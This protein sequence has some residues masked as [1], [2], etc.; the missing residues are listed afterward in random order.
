MARTPDTKLARQEKK[1]KADAAQQDAL[2]REVDE[3]VRQGDMEDFMG[4]W[5]KPLLALIVVGLLGFAG[6]LYWDRQQEQAMESDSEALVLALDALEAGN[7]D[8][9]VERLA[10]IEGDGTAAV[11]AKMLRAGMAS[12]GGNDAEAAKLFGEVADNAAAPEALRDLARIR[13]TA[14]RFD[15]MEPA[16]VIAALQP[17]AVPGEPFFA[18]AGELVAHAYLAQGNR[19]EA[20]ALFAQI[21]RD[22]NTPESARARMV[23]MA[24]LLGVD[25]VDDVQELLDERRIDPPAAP[26]GDAE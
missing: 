16:A 7:N 2:M 23:N 20:G 22:E 3:A 24:G 18:S 15:D 19:E 12:E 14:L 26:A 21:S 8:A 9:T 4:K 17:L 11:S 5:G 6:Y 25:T 13:Q 1:A 10:A